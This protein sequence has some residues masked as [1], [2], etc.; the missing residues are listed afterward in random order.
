M[1]AQQA[2]RHTAAQIRNLADIPIMDDEYLPIPV[3]DPIYNSVQIFNL[4]LHI[5]TVLQ[6]LFPSLSLNLVADI[7]PTALPLAKTNIYGR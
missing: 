4:S 2:M 3:A 7:H 1:R 5:L 6:A